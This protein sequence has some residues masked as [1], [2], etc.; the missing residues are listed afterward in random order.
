MGFS[1]SS[2]S[3]MNVNA[4]FINQLQAN[5]T[6]IVGEK[7][8]SISRNEDG[9]V[10]LSKQGATERSSF[11]A[12][13]HGSGSTATKIENKINSELAKT[14]VTFK[15]VDKMFNGAPSPLTNLSPHKEAALTYVMHTAVRDQIYGI[16]DGS[17]FS[18]INS[19]PMAVKAQVTDAVATHLLA[20]GQ[21]YNL[22]LSGLT[23]ENLVAVMDQM[24]DVPN[25]ELLDMTRYQLDKTHRKHS[26]DDEVKVANQFSFKYI[27][28]ALPE[29]SS[30]VNDTLLNLEKNTQDQHIRE[31][32][33]SDPK[34][35]A[36]FS[37]AQAAPDT[38]KTDTSSVSSTA[39]LSDLE[40]AKQ[41]TNNNTN[42]QGLQAAPLYAGRIYG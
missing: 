42:K 11:S 31:Q 36:F 30:L 2:L 20:H 15:L 35:P 19:D 38:I 32:I 25:T 26:A 8:F 39:K 7:T 29:L 3:N 21:N 18:N 28:N 6:I 24:Y 10:S 41:L 4:D 27:G 34:A 14:N 5:D 13:L 23:K 17:R 16:F 1:V 33:K 22:D 12:W 40:Y 9:T 37:E